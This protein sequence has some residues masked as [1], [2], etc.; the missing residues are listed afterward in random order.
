VGKEAGRAAEI[1]A[2]VDEEGSEASA[3]CAAAACAAWSLVE[4]DAAE[5]AERSGAG[6]ASN[7]VAAQVRSRLP[8]LSFELSCTFDQVLSNDTEG[9]IRAPLWPCLKEL[10]AQIC[11]AACPCCTQRHVQH[12]ACTG[13]PTNLG[14]SRHSA[15][16][17]LAASCPSQHLGQP[18]SARHPSFPCSIRPTPLPAYLVPP[19]AH[20]P[21]ITL[22]RAPLHGL[23]PRQASPAP[24]CP[25]RP[26]CSL[27]FLAVHQFPRQFLASPHFICW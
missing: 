23:V 8:S 11:A 20:P 17:I 6:I 4:G 9:Q 16:P 25:V 15:H 7:T 24:S 22:T 14:L 1:E 26:L 5:N 19:P 21:T 3:G 13:S 27:G 18:C 12:M 2:A 10:V